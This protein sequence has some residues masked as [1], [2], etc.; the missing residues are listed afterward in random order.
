MLSAKKVDT[1]VRHTPLIIPS[2]KVWKHSDPELLSFFCC[3]FCF[4]F[5]KQAIKKG[6]LYGSCKISVR[7]TC[8]SSWLT[9]GLQYKL[10]S[11]CNFSVILFGEMCMYFDLLIICSHVL[12]GDV[13]TLCFYEVPRDFW[14]CF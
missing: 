1:T 6:A 9:V 8:V 7:E 13:Y 10:D 2:S 12:F 4:P 5:S 14:H 3:F 11:F